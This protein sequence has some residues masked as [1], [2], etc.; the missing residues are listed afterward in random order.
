MTNKM[1]PQQVVDIVAAA[2]AKGEWPDLSCLDLSGLSLTHL[3]MCGADFTGSNLAGADLRFSNMSGSQFVRA[4][5]RRARMSGSAL[6]DA[7]FYGADLGGAT[8]RYVD[9]RGAYLYRADLRNADLRH[10]N[11]YGVDLYDADLRY[12]QLTGLLIDGL[13]SGH[14]IF[15]PTHEGWHLTIGCWEGTTEE[16]REMIAKDEGWPE[17]R[18]KEI[19]MRRPMLEAMADACEAYA[20]AHPDALTEARAAADRWKENIES[21]EAV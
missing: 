9:L 1:T 10:A 14:L 19:S 15:I 20:A 18:G 8:L 3:N 21:A 7:N 4:D 16:L 12:A 5:L 13:P 2:H 17:A 6:R 11:L